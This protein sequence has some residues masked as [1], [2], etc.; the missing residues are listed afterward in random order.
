VDTPRPA[1]EREG[2]GERHRDEKK[3]SQ[4]KFTLFF[5]VIKIPQILKYYTSRKVNHIFVPNL[6]PLC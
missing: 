2:E 1:A 5:G 6:A 3:K 4:T